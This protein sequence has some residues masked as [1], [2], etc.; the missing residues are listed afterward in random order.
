MSQEI[1]HQ[2]IK[3]HQCKVILVFEPNVQL[4]TNEDAGKTSFEKMYQCNFLDHSQVKTLRNEISQNNGTIDILIENGRIKHPSKVPSIF[5]ISPDQ[6][7]EETSNKIVVTL[8]V[9]I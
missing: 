7:I 4:H 6:F 9:S 5:S 3:D 8:N 1:A 2:M